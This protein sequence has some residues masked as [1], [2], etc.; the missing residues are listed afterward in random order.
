MPCESWHTSREGTSRGAGDARP[1]RVHARLSRTDPVL[2]Q[3]ILKSRHVKV[4][5]SGVGMMGIKPQGAEQE[6]AGAPSQCSALRGRH[7]AMSRGGTSRLFTWA[8]VWDA[9]VRVVCVS[10]AQR[11]ARRS[12][13]GRRLGYVNADRHGITKTSPRLRG[14]RSMSRMWIT[15]M[16]TGDEG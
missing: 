13:H 9:R 5:G 8:G 12:R 11:T 10:F 7:R 1:S 4:S 14:R 2:W 15:D 6:S 16:R 3:Q